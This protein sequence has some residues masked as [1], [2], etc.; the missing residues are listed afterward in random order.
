MAPQHK[1]PEP[2]DMDNFSEVYGFTRTMLGA[3]CLDKWIPKYQDGLESLFAESG[4]DVRQSATLDAMH[5][6]LGSPGAPPT[7]K[8]PPPLWERLR[9]PKHPQP[10][11]AP[12]AEQYAGLL[13]D[14][15]KQ[16][17]GDAGGK[18]DTRCAL[19][20]ML[21]HFYLA[22]SAGGQSIWIA[23]NP[24]AY[25][26]WTYDLFDGKS[27]HAIKEA[28]TH[29]TELFGAGN[30]KLFAEAFTLARK[31]SMDAVARLGS[32]DAAT[33]DLVKR[34]FGVATADNLDSV[35]Q[36]ISMSFGWISQAC[37]AS[38]VIFA[39]DPP[40][41]SQH[42][43]AYAA[44]NFGKDEAMRVIYIYKS[45]LEFSQKDRAGGRP[46]LWNAALVIIHELAHREIGTDDKKY[47]WQGIKPGR[48]FKPEDAI[49]NAD[50]Y[51][52]FA[53]DLAGVLKPADFREVYK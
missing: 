46:K 19:L 24:T 3:K 14:I 32:P 42:K 2:G 15:A 16:S 41:R 5:W 20:K 21:K 43:N 25:S 49:W 51:A 40:G 10:A 34:W 26:K 30:R 17:L 44:T 6:I 31:W 36:W 4:P 38:T 35:V 23:D 53:A 33:V 18:I 28:L 12:S 9:P 39:D 29:N 1:R 7:I 13:I 37:N 45:Y 11:K 48:R 27:E 22:S 47:N 8:S 50:S 52:Y